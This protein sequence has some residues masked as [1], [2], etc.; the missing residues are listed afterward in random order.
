MTTV[1]NTT[2]TNVTGPNLNVTATENNATKYF[3]NFYSIP[4]NVSSDTNDAITSFFEEYVPNAQAARNLASSV[5]Y[6]AMAQ[7]LDPLKVLSDFQSL[8]KGQLNNYLVAFLNT[9]RAPT[10]VLGINTGKKTGQY[11]TRAI[12]A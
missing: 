12:L 5:L 10:S 8:P 11:I 2:A 1:Q 3:N 4:F 7:N 9:S 6:T